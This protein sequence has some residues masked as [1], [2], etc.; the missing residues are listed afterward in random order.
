METVNPNPKED[1]SRWHAQN[2]ARARGELSARQATRVLAALLERHG[3]TE[4]AL[5]LLRRT[6]DQGDRYAQQD[7]QRM[8]KRSRRAT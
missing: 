1:L 3:R 6:A 5:T 4:E 7:L 2:R 8:I